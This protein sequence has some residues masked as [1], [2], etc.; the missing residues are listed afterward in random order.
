MEALL[1]Q[2]DH[3]RKLPTHYN[4]Q[5][6]N[7]ALEKLAKAL[8]NASSIHSPSAS[9]TSA[10][11][12]ADWLLQRV[13]S[14]N[15]LDPPALAAAVWDA[16]HI[17]D[18]AQQQATLFDILGAD[19]TEVLFELMPHLDEIR[20]K[21]RREDLTHTPATTATTSMDPDEHARQQLVQDYL[22]AAQM[23]AVYQA[24]LDQLVVPAK[25]GTHSLQ[26]ASDKQLVKKAQKA[27]KKAQQLLQR[28]REVGALLD[29]SVLPTLTD[30]SPLGE[31][32]LRNRE[33][34]QSL[35][36]SLLPEGSK[37]YYD[38]RGLPRGAISEELPGMRRVILPAVPRDE[39]QLHERLRID[40]IMN[41]TEGLAFQGTTSL[42]PMQSTVFATAF[43]KRDNLLIC[44]PTGAGKTNVALLTVVSH[45]RDV[46]LI[47]SDRESPI[48]SGKKVVYIAPMKAL[49]QEVVE[50]FSEKL[51]PLKLIVREL[52]G[53]MQ[54]TRAQS[55][56]ANVIVTTPEKWDVVTR[57]GGAEDTSLGN[58]CG[59]LII[60][61]V[62]L[63]RDLG[64]TT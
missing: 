45:F 23:A 11:V 59:L 7:S 17:P 21:I 31:G 2:Y 40:Q 9:S 60:D 50:K 62:H 18:E 56:S 26:R 48:E 38:D 53:D 46:G 47:P 42:N 19:G 6:V 35:Q 24:E 36:A 12:T 13:S 20:T 44:A 33:D 1:L 51:K 43:T 55:D 5:R 3:E 39:S 22:E 25:G 15:T 32:G 57:K 58:Q 27:Q 34:L 28:A 37:A 29:E 52:T 49:A 10:A 54:L 16:A 64:R 41:A 61:E 8:R 30:W 14:V 4:I 63:V